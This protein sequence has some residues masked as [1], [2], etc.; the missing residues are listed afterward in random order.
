MPPDWSRAVLNHR[1]PPQSQ[2]SWDSGFWDV[3]AGE[4]FDWF[5]RRGG[6]ASV[7]RQMQRWDEN[8]AWWRDGRIESWSESGNGHGNGILNENESGMVT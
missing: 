1:W 6:V 3:S 8:V 5:E 7:D 4:K 2:S